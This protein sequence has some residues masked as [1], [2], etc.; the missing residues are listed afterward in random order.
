MCDSIRRSESEIWVN[1]WVNASGLKGGIPF[2]DWDWASSNFGFESRL[3]RHSHISS[4]CVNKRP[5]PTVKGVPTISTSSPVSPTRG[6]KRQ[7][8]P[9]MCVHICVHFVFPSIEHIV[10]CKGSKLVSKLN[11]VR[12]QL[13]ICM[14]KTPLVSVRPGFQLIFNMESSKLKT[15]W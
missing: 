9:E 6:P 1:I 12:N 13:A 15:S 3:S 7:V 14:D 2:S 5:E 8:V 10:S 4:G 11:L